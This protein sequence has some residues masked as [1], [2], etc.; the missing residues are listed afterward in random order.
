MIPAGLKKSGAS[1]QKSLSGYGMLTGMVMPVITFPSAFLS[2]FSMLLI[3]EFSEANA[4]H[5]K[6]NIQ[7]ISKRVF[8]ITL[9]FSILVTGIFV[10]FAK[11]LGMLI[12][13]DPEPGIYISILAPVI[14]L[15]YLDSVVD[16]MLKG[17]NEQLSYL[18]YNMI[19]SVIRVFLIF[20]LLPLC[21]L[22]GVIIVIFV[23]EILNSTLSIA[24]LLKVTHLQFQVAN[25][26][27]KPILS[28]ALPGFL[29][30]FLVNHCGL[31]FSSSLSKVLLEIFIMAACYVS[32]L[33]LTR[34][35]GK[36]E[37]QWIKNLFLRS[38][39]SRPLPHQA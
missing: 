21:G 30:L 10:F 36:E 22:K 26:L 38:R 39:S 14:P 28:A 3:P 24:R 17:L 5:H 16:G 33:F 23:S 32:L 20:T 9:L 15:M 18:S 19:D 12:Y 4:K 34:C 7:Y 13:N 2:S 27:L 25:W 37:C 35:I 1:Y 6:R 11:D 31:S 29:L 8:Q